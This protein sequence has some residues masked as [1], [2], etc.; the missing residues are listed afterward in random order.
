MKTNDYVQSLFKDYEETPELKDF[1]EELQSNLED[2]IASLVKKGLPEN[3]AFAKATAELG[4]IGVL[5]GQMSLKRRQEV[6]QDAYLGI[7]RYM[8]APRVIAYVF[9]GAV[10]AFGFITAAL[11]YFSTRGEIVPQA[12]LLDPS[13]PAGLVPLFGVLMPFTTLGIAGFVFLGL[14]QES[15]ALYPMGKKRALW[16]S[17]AAVLITFGLTMMPLAYFATQK[18]ISPLSAIGMLIPFGLPGAALLAFLILT[19]KSRFKPWMKDRAT[20]ALKKEHEM[21]SDPA[22]TRF[23]LFSGAIWIGAAACFFLFGFLAGFRYSWTAFVF[24]IALQLMAHGMLYKTGAAG[25]APEA[26]RP[27]S[28]TEA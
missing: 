26:R 3:E 13:G 17:L 18:D 19:E 16:Y 8:K 11:A 15:S 7:R 6:Y 4:D 23:G 12:D 5:A 1:I 2:R 25:K 20:E 22:V 21:M 9:F 28:E 27:D 24:A 10:L 14:T